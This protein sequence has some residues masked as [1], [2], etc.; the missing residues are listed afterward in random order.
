MDL[1]WKHLIPLSLAWLLLIAAVID[2][3]WGGLILVPVMLLAAGLL[4]R[5]TELGAFRSEER[6]AHPVHREPA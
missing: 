6:R 2:W 5:A 1:G 4:F 3:G